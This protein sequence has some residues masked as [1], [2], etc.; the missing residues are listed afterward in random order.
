MPNVKQEQRE[1]PV[2]LA[3]LH[4]D[5]NF[6]LE[7]VINQ[8]TISAL[9]SDIIS[10]PKDNKDTL[11]TQNHQQTTQQQQPPSQ[12]QQQ[13]LQAQRQQIVSHDTHHPHQHH[14]HH[15]Q[16]QQSHPN[17]HQHTPS[18]HLTPIKIEDVNKNNAIKN[19]NTAPNQQHLASHM[20]QTHQMHPTQHMQHQQSHQAPGQSLQVCFNINDYKQVVRATSILFL[21]ISLKV[22]TRPLK[23]FFYKGLTF[24]AY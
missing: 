19:H 12:S 1:F 13:S 24:L 10:E 4:S 16:Q 3:D 22:F 17:S 9:I 15:S 18:Y 5:M 7:D 8:D 11:F 21:F 14:H 2:D 20:Q 6:D 23:D